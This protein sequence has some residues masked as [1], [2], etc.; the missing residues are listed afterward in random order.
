VIDS[1]SFPERCWFIPADY[2]RPAASANN[3]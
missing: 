3:R 1:V 2:E